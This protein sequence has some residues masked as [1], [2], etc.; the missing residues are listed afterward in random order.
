MVKHLYR[1]AAALAFAALTLPN[2]ASAQPHLRQTPGSQITVSQC[3]PHL[4]T[5]AQAHPWI[6]PYGYWHYHGFFP[7]EEGFLEITYVNN[8]NVA[9]TEIDF[10]LVARHSLIA[11]VTDKGTFSP[12]ATVDHEFSV[13]RQIFPIGTEF[14]YCAVMRVIYTD[15]ST[16]TNPR[17]PQE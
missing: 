6:D 7:Y 9:A 8:A 16:W 14:P 17:I 10:G 3:R 12:G 11:V 13:D 15:G 1:G 4:H 2:L 5:A